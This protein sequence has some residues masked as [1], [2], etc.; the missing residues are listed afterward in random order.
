MAVKVVTLGHLN[1]RF[2]GDQPRRQHGLCI[3]MEAL[4]KSQLLHDTRSC[5]FEVFAASE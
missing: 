1:P 5:S 2:P 4:I 3:V